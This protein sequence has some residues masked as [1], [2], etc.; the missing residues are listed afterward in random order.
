L[1]KVEVVGL[2]RTKDRKEKKGRFVYRGK[3]VNHL[4]FLK[5]WFKYANDEKGEEGVCPSD[6]EEEELFEMKKKKSPL[7][8]S[9]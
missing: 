1:V 3:H 2:G 7:E 8:V 5:E 6:G 4:P 9:R